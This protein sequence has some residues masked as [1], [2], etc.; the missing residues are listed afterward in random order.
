[1]FLITVADSQGLSWYI[2]VAFQDAGYKPCLFS[3]GRVVHPRNALALLWFAPCQTKKSIGFYPSILKGNG[4]S[5]PSIA[6]RLSMDDM[7]LG[8]ARGDLIRV[9]LI[10]YA[11]GLY[12]VLSLDTPLTA[13]SVPAH[14]IPEG[15]IPPAAKLADR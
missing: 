6:R 8:H 15:D 2:P 7:R 11:K 9:G 5:D 4:Y 3:P 12:Q 14:I 10:A 13:P 1:L